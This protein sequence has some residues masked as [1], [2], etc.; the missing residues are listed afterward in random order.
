MTAAE[1][2]ALTPTAARPQVHTALPCAYH[3]RVESE[4][5]DAQSP[6]SRSNGVRRRCP[7]C[8]GAARLPGMT[9]T[10]GMGK[11]MGSA[12]GPCPTCDGFGYLA[13]DEG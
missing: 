9:K 2:G 8:R 4:S 13:E 12:Y 11:G 10:T 5:P 7:E 1:R 3:R 6:V